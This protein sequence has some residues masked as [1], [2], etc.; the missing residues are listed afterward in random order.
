MP[1][2]ENELVC[3]F[4][5][6]NWCLEG[7]CWAPA[8]SG[9][10]GKQSF[11]CSSCSSLGALQIVNSSTERLGGSVPYLGCEL[12]HSCRKQVKAM[13]AFP[14]F[15]SSDVTL[16]YRVSRLGKN[17][18]GGLCSFVFSEAEQKALPCVR[19]HVDYEAGFSWETQ[20]AAAF[21]VLGRGAAATL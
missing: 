5:F 9:C 20:P 10:N 12:F 21:F 13:Q 7:A 14:A 8:G 18:L 19:S 11:W 2:F 6:L 4:F 17:F 16:S 1:S 15:N 3:F